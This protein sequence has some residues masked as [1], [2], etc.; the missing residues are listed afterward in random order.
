MKK[1]VNFENLICLAFFC[2][3]LYLVRFEIY[4]IPTNVWEILVGIVL[5]LWAL[6]C[7]GRRDALQCVSTDVV[8]KKYFYPVAL[9]SVGLTVS[10][11]VNMYVIDYVHSL[12]IIKSWFVLPALFFVSARSIVPREKI[13]NVFTAYYFSALA[14]AIISLGYYLA[15]AVTFDGRL[16]GIFNSPNYLAMYLSPGIIGGLFLLLSAVER[17]NSY[18]QKIQNEN[19]KNKNDNAKLK[20]I[21]YII[22]LLIIF[23]VVY[24][25]YSYSAWIAVFISLLITQAIKTMCHPERSAR[26]PARQGAESRDLAANSG[27]D[28]LWQ[29]L[30]NKINKKHIVTIAIL[31]V[32]FFSQV[33]NK[34]FTDFINF[35]ERSSLSSRVMIWKSAGKILEDNWILGIGPG[36]FQDKY[37]EY[38]KHFPPYLEWAVPHPH[39]LFLAFWLAGG[40]LG[41][42]GFLWL[43]GL[44]FKDVFAMINVETP[45]RGVSMDAL[46]I[47][48]AIMLYILLHGLVDTTYFKN[49]LAV[50]FW[51][52]F[53]AL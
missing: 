31:V 26:L 5:I 13:D 52:C 7:C 36:N 30:K 33:N 17:V 1:I 6:S 16:Q 43:V 53:L 4:G 8:Y 48:L 2:L 35:D 42:V 27:K 28:V 32:L 49:D 41:L 46:Y 21:F 47:S 38:Q 51:M 18:G 10:T 9:M 20:I 39:N 37:L 11:Y 24:K 44:F 25:T 19:L 34:K 3:P 45:R 29:L 23:F 22:Y 14:V 50:V 12:G 40:I 15:G